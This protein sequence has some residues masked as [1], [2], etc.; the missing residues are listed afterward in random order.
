[1]GLIKQVKC[2]RCDRQYSSLR[3]RCPYCGARKNRGG[4]RS[5]YSENNKWQLIAGI[6]I[7]I[8]IIVTVVVLI[9]TSLNSGKKDNGKDNVKNSPNIT[10]GEGVNSVTNPPTTTP[11]ATPSSD[12][13][14]GTTDPSTTQSPEPT[15]PAAT[16]NSITLNREDFTLSKIGEQWQMQAT[17][18]PANPSVE[19]TWKS[20]DESVCVIN[21][22]GLV[23][24]VNKGTTTIVAIAGGKEAKCIVRVTATATT[25][26]TTGGTTGSST[27]G[28]TTGGPVSLSHTDV[29]IHSGS[30]ETFKLS[31]SGASGTPEYSTSNSA[32]ATVSSTGTVKAISP[33]TATIKV[34]VDGKTLEC[35]VRVIV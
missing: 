35:I 15:T 11:P 22:T 8:A 31:V 4:K 5:A 33:G 24:A 29:T 7:L 10:A 17:L 12:P 1:M 13:N 28:T 27:G 20:N 6:V 18:S 14:A 32:Y 30:G 21:A 23:T 19:V 2:G 16:V 9:V 3:S 25:G 26:T 34:T